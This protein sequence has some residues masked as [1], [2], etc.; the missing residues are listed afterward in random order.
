M[1]GSVQHICN[2]CMHSCFV[3][4][5][6]QIGGHAGPVYPRA[7]IVVVVLI[8]VSIYALGYIEI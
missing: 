4:L 7:L 5:F 1:C 6:E 8:V 3:I 2:L